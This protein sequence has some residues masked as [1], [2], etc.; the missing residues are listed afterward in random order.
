MRYL[1]LLML[2]AGCNESRLCCGLFMQI[3]EKESDIPVTGADIE[4]IAI[5]EAELNSRDYGSVLDAEGRQIGTTDDAG[6]IL[7]PFCGKAIARDF[8]NADFSPNH[9]LVLL[10]IRQSTPEASGIAALRFD[11]QNPQNLWTIRTF[12][13][14][15][16]TLNVANRGILCQ[17]DHSVDELIPPNERSGMSRVTFLFVR[18]PSDAA[19]A[20]IDDVYADDEFPGDPL[21]SARVEFATASQADLVGLTA[22]EYLNQ[23]GRSVG[24]TNGCGYIDVRV[25]TVVPPYVQC[26]SGTVDRVWLFRIE[27]GADT[28]TIVLRPVADDREAR[29]HDFSGSAFETEDRLVTIYSP[30][31]DC[32]CEFGCNEPTVTARCD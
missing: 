30:F 16:D 12:S 17:G 10:R 20:S 22:D 19:P 21:G 2:L 11:N 7:M 27:G 8:V 23:F 9:D 32:L 28:G 29:F 13:V 14:E 6:G 26:E 15:S 18:R 1:P 3:T 4:W 24:H 31:A 5:D 25:Q